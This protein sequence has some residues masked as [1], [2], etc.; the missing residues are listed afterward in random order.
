MFDKVCHSLKYKSNFFG[1]QTS[2]DTNTDHFTLLAL[3]VWGKYEQK[4]T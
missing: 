1:Q 2:L 4:I 3:R